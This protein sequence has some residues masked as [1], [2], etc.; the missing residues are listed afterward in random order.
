MWE[1]IFSRVL[2]A[3]VLL[4]AALPG[5]LSPAILAAAGSQFGPGLA[6][7]P[8][9]KAALGAAV[10]LP[11]ALLDVQ[12]PAIQAFGRGDFSGHERLYGFAFKKP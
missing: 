12:D 1:L 8:A 4:A 10:P 11:A 5:E 7:D 6:L 3:A 2:G 9:L